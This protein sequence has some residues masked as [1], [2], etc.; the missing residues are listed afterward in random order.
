MLRI[1]FKFP[2]LYLSPIYPI[3]CLCNCKFPLLNLGLFASGLL[4]ADSSHVHVSLHRC[5]DYL[6]GVMVSFIV[7]PFDVPNIYV[8]SPGSDIR[9][10]SQWEGWID[11]LQ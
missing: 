2:L 4:M 1:L 7:M 3:F 11:H 6:L 10:R 5:L 8:H 9:V